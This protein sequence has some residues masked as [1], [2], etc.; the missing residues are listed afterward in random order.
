MSNQAIPGTKLTLISKIPQGD[1]VFSFEFEPNAPLTWQAGQFIK[2][3]LPHP[4]TDAAGTSRRFTI[5]GAPHEAVVRITTRIT[6]S[7][8]KQALAALPLNAKVTLL[9]L[10][11]G[12]FIWRAAPRPHIFVAQG[13]GI[14]PFYAI[15]AS[16]AHEHLSTPAHLIYA[17]L[18]DATP[19]FKRELENWAG[20][21][22]N[23]E[24]TFINTPITAALL[25]EKFPD[26][27]S[28]YV[29]SCGPRPLIKLCLPPYNLPPTHLIQ[30]NFPGYAASSY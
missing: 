9:D 16:R 2:I 24:V 3:D 4:E 7:T 8:F 23:F 26:L 20:A 5:A 13:I 22:L 1:E 27:A 19:L 17:N 14:T 12:D 30:D 18:H 25:A 29:Y 11:A 10:P 21:G 28:K 15:L 6:N